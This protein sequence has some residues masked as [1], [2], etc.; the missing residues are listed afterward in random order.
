MDRA[1]ASGASAT[2]PTPPA[3]PSTGYPTAGNPALA[4]PPTKPGKYWYYMIT[5]ELRN[6]VS[7]AGLSPLQSDV[8]QILQA[9]PA[10]LASRP[11]MA[12]NLSVNGYQKLPGGLVLQWGTAIVGTSTTAASLNIT[13][14]IAF[15]TAGLFSIASG[16][17]VSIGGVS[18][19]ARAQTVTQTTL[20]V[21]HSATASFSQSIRWF[22]IGY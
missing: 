3:S 1:Y 19:P 8:T 11:E 15:P 9:L 16:T 12:R 17:D 2:P 18:A 13:L 21:V 20:T 7:A 4:L 6:V 5:E 14:P 22:V 10:A